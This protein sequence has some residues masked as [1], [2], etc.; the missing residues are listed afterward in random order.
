V[1]EAFGQSGETLTWPFFLSPPAERE[2]QIVLLFPQVVG[3][4]PG[5]DSLTGGRI[6]GEGK[7]RFGFFNTK[8]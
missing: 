5:E 2:K 6:D 7:L 4:Q 8:K 3:M 1:G